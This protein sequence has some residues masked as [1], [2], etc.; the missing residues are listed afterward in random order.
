[1]GPTTLEELLDRE[2]IRDCLMRY[3]RGID[4]MDR[5][6]LE[7]VY[8]PDALD[9]HGNFKGTAADFLDLALDKVAKMDAT[10]F[11]IGN[12]LIELQGAVAHVET[13]FN[14]YHRQVREDGSRYDLNTSGR[15]I[16]RFEKRGG[17]WRVADRLVKHDWFREYEDSGDWDAGV[18][19]IKYG[20]S[21]KPNDPVYTRS[22]Q[23][24]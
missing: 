2:S 6:L 14:V 23:R 17:E 24:G 21:R 22:S 18:H 3:C 9:D 16:D 13:Y 12:I 4:R 10:A 19:G 20:I 8:W 11:F 5:E 7:S 1:M 15:Y